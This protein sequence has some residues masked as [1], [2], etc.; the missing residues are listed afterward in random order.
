[1]SRF[2]VVWRGL[3]RKSRGGV[4]LSDGARPGLVR[5]L[6]SLHRVGLA[7]ELPTCDRSCDVAGC[8]TIA[9]RQLLYIFHAS[10][11]FFVLIVNCDLRIFGDSGT[12]IA[13]CC[14]PSSDGGS[15][16]GTVDNGLLT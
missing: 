7:I 15:C 8:R 4:N 13:G 1:M 10:L 2:G 12:E 14:Q 6:S 11:Y 16:I 9:M 3:A 5:E